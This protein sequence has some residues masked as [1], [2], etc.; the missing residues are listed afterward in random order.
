[1]GYIKVNLMHI[2]FGNV[3]KLCFFH[4]KRPEMAP[5]ALAS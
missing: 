4:L 3:A 5:T 1:M 2:L